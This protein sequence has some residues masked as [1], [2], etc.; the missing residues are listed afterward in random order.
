MCDKKAKR[1]TVLLLALL[2]MSG[3]LITGASLGTISLLT[4]RQSRVIDDSISAFAA[5]ESG[6]EQ[7]L[8]QARRVGLGASALASSNQDVSSATNA[9]P[10]MTNGSHWQR[11]VV[12]SEPT[13][14][15]AIPKDKDYEVVLWDPE[16]PT[17]PAGIGSLKFTWSDNCGGTSG[18][19]VL[20]TGWDPTI[21]G[22]SPFSPD[23]AFHGN[24]PT[25]TFLYNASG[26]VDNSY[27][28]ARAYRVRL[29]A[30]GCDIY[31]LAISG[32]SASNAGGSPVNIPSRIA[33][34]STGQYGA[35]K[36][37]MELRLNRLQPL[38][39]VFDYIIFSQC[40]LLKNL[41][42]APCP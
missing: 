22:T 17:V 42:P 14:F 6:A 35:A 24:S 15:A 23:I 3:I 7:S 34:T 29:R 30:K 19:E 41:S 39:G 2:I 1:G 31:N 10:P 20:A 38:S 36:Q 33:V 9:G 26:V 5:A 37:G 18:L 32:Y 13:V 27:A 8:Y 4:L 11:S 25:L 21:G 12:T 40:S 16:R 28:A